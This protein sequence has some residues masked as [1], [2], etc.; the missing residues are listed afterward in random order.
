MAATWPLVLHADDATPDE[1]RDARITTWVLAWDAHAFKTDP[2]NLFQAPIFF[3]ET[4][5]LAYT[6]HMTGLAVF[7]APINW[8]TGDPY[9]AHN[10]VFLLAIAFAAFAASLAAFEL[11]GS[12]PAALVGGA[13]FGFAPY[14]VNHEMHLQILAAGWIPMALFGVL[15]WWRTGSTR[16]LVLGT[17]SGVLAALTSWYQAAF[18]A[19]MLAT[20]LTVFLIVNRPPRILRMSLQ[21]AVA[22]AL[23]AAALWPFAAPYRRLS[24]RDPAYTRTLSDVA[25]LSAGPESYLAAPPSNLLYGSLTSRWSG[26]PQSVELNLFPGL[27]T[28]GLAAV[29]A[30]AR[31]RDRGERAGAAGICVLIA[32]SVTLSFGAASSGVRR[33][34]PW[35]WLSDYTELFRG[36]RAAARAHVLVVLGLSLLAA[37]GVRFLLERSSQ[38]TVVAGLLIA[39]VVVEGAGVPRSLGP[40]PRAGAVDAKLADRPA[41]ILVLPAGREHDADHMLRATAHWRPLVNGVAGYTPAVYRDLVPILERTPGAALVEE[42]RARRIAT[43]VLHLDEMGP[44]GPEFER[45]FAAQEGVSFIA[46][47]GPVVVYGVA[48]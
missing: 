18:V 6:D 12:F 21:A 38:K 44:Q 46:R 25:R 47:D 14:W 7:A 31:K 43:V 48:V 10:V 22:L 3:P 41:G 37:F 23:A 20:M 45:A 1:L 39:V 8:L 35:A 29:G 33:H 9:L 17:V 26:Y 42:L 27:A 19:V 5:A 36:L 11:T 24:E 34:L 30:A 32:A 16:A 2:T 15:R 13:A 28:V 40:D 4:D